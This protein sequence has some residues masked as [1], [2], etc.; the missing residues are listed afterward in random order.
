VFAPALSGSASIGATL[1]DGCTC[2]A[3]NTNLLVLSGMVAF[4]TGVHPHAFYFS[5]L[6]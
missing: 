4:L 6:C 1:S 5:I 3:T 2:P